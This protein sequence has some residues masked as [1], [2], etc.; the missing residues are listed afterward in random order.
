MYH[1]SADYLVERIKRVAP[2]QRVIPLETPIALRAALGEIEVLFAP[3]PPRDGWAG[4]ER[5]R[6]IQVLGTGVDTLLPSPDLPPQVEIAGV[7]GVFAPDVAEHA[8]A[9]L[10]A[11][12]RR[13]PQLLDA[14]RGR[15]F[16]ATPRPS[17]AGEVVTIVGGGEIGRRVARA[18]TA[19]DMR[20]RVVSRTGRGELQPGVELLPADALASAVSDARFVVIA[21]PLTPATTNLFDARM[22]ARMRS[23]A[24]LINVARGGIVDEA[25]LV[26]AVSARRL[27]GA[28][29]D[30]FAEEPLPPD[31]VLWTVPGITITPHVGGLGIGY[32]ERCIE[33]LLANVAALEGGTP[34]RGVVDRDVGY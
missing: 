18:T 1:E 22:L 34:R 17:I 27:G 3:M 8:L 30:V 5:L 4:A 29:L 15:S 25:A 20:V 2:M 9:L 19:L 14:Q 31:H 7:R 6:L 12:A 11:H 32:I 10:L 13:L 23:D 28:A 16:E 21:V 24:Y 26:E 33:A